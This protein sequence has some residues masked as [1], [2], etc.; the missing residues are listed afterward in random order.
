MSFLLDFM[1]IYF[2]KNLFDLI[3]NNIIESQTDSYCLNFNFKLQDLKSHY[4]LASK[5]FI[6][7]LKHFY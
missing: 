6:P 3:A 7:N 2:A 1:N 5:Y 4:R